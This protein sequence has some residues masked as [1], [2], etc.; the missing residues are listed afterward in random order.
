MAIIWRIAMSI[1]GDF[2]DADHKHLIN[3]V[4]SFDSIRP[5]GA[6][7]GELAA[8]LDRL[9]TCVL[10]HFEREERF[11]AAAHFINAA[12]HGRYHDSAM[13]ELDAIRS[14][15]ERTLNA[16]Q[17]V[18]FHRRVTG[19]LE[20]WLIDHIT[21][22]DMLMKPFIA[23]LSSRARDAGSLEQTVPLSEAEFQTRDSSLGMSMRRSRETAFGARRV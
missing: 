23:E 5:V 9:N 22:S 14:E 10:I 11:Q 17:L 21:L 3:L 7:R 18:G 12:A 13:G 15:C 6:M 16:N 1:D 8:I 2:I 4:N 19:F 20:D